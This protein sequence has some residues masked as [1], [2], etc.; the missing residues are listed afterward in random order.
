V[1]LSAHFDDIEFAC[2]SGDLVPVELRPNLQRLVTEV[3]EPLR[4]LWGAPIIV[5]S[6]YRSPAYNEGLRLVSDE[7][8]RREGRTAGGVAQHSQHLTASAADVR[9]VELGAVPR[10][11][12]LVEE[13]IQGA[14]LPAL[15]GFGR[16]PGWL[17]LDIRPRLAGRVVRWIGAGVGSE[18]AT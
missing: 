15:G 12:S 9:P 11:T 18:P 13:M 8:A 17:H 6:G 10:F 2:R 16:Y 7:R 4:R 1:K 3:L 14:Q 5:V